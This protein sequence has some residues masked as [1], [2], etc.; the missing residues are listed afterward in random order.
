MTRIYV[1]KNDGEF[2]RYILYTQSMGMT[3]VYCDGFYDPDSRIDE[4]VCNG[5]HLFTCIVGFTHINIS[6]WSLRDNLILAIANSNF[7]TLI[8]MSIDKCGKW[9]GQAVCNMLNI[10][11]SLTSLC[12]LDCSHLNSRDFVALCSPIN[13]LTSL[14]INRA[15]N[16]LTATLIALITRSECLVEF[17]ALN[18]LELDRSA[19]QDFCDECRPDVVLIPRGSVLFW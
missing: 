17:T 10:C 9:T 8:H 4:G 1:T 13:I 11:K 16:L 14:T 15:R 12:L 18:C 6:I 3:H 19:A 5:K 2:D 7:T